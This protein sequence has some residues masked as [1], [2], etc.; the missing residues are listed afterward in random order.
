MKIPRTMHGAGVSRSPCPGP[1]DAVIV[2]IRDPTEARSPFDRTELPNPQLRP[3][4]VVIYAHIYIYI[5]MYMYPRCIHFLRAGAVF[6]FA[7][8]MCC[9]TMA[10][11]RPEAPRPHALS[12]RSRTKSESW[13]WPCRRRDKPKTPCCQ[14]PSVG[15]FEEVSYP[16]GP[17]WKYWVATASEHNPVV[18]EVP[19]I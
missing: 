4:P 17:V 3:D 7:S 12:N 18:T 5:H 6:R 2:W 13:F 11:P 16:E 9:S 1:G 19:Y 8:S 10:I 15:G 14:S